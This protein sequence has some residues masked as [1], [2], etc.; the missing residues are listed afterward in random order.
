MLILS[1]F[2]WRTVF[3]INNNNIV[4]SQIHNKIT[5]Q[6]NE[7]Y[8]WP[9]FSSL[10]SDFEWAFVHKARKSNFDSNRIR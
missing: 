3:Q 6:I 5:A 9:L 10:I 1:Y 8:P 2:I 4:V 7:L